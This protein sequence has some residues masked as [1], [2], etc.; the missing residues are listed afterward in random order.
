MRPVAASRHHASPAPAGSRAA[1]NGET[2]TS[3]SFTADVPGA[4]QVA[5]YG[6]DSK[7]RKSAVSTLTVTANTCGSNAPAV[8]N[9]TATPGNPGIGG[10]VALTASVSDADNQGPCNFG[11]SLSYSWALLS[12]PAGSTATL[13]SAG[14]TSPSFVPQVPGTYVVGLVVKDSA[15]LSSTLATQSITVTPT[16]ACGANPPV[17]KLV[18]P[19][20]VGSCTNQNDTG[21]T[22]T[23]TVTGP[24]AAVPNYV[25]RAIPNNNT[26]RS[27][28]IQLDATPST[29]ADNAAP[30]NQSQLLSYAW[31]MVAAPLG[32]GWSWQGFNG[33]GNSSGGATNLVNPTL[34]LS[35]RG[36]YT[37]QLTVTDSA[38]LSTNSI[39]QVLTQ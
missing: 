15:G 9:I 22:V 5:V 18:N 20:A 4:Y 13:N 33:N 36:T 32:G 7:G 28:Q 37:V 29:D 17:A 6:T 26:W 11:Q 8:A 14:L 30:C 19:P 31:Q 35:G 39:V 27:F 21:C 12:A 1:L 25:I 24:V 34:S 2:L 38:G 23:P 10:V 3:P 16:P